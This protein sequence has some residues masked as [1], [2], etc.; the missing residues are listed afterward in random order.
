MKIGPVSRAFLSSSSRR[1]PGPGRRTRSILTDADSRIMPVAGGGFEQALQRPSPQRWRPYSLL[2]VTERTCISRP[3]TDKRQIEFRRSGSVI[4]RDSLHRGAGR[5]RD[6]FS[7]QRATSVEANVN[8]CA[9]R[10]RS[11]R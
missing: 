9:D 4:A 5:A 10:P 6:P 2:V 3:P 1:W 8:A 7:G 11:R